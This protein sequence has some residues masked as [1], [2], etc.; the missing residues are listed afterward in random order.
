LQKKPIT[1]ELELTNE[2]MKRIADSVIELRSAMARRVEETEARVRELGPTPDRQLVKIIR[3]A[4][5]ERHVALREQAEKECLGVLKPQQRARLREIQLQAE[6]PLAFT[7]PELVAALKMSP[8]QAEL[9]RRA[10]EEGREQIVSSSVV[11]VYSSADKRPS[12]AASQTA[13]VAER[14]AAVKETTEARLETKNAVF[15]LLNKWQRDRY[16]RML[17]KSFD[18]GSLRGGN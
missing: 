13:N 12:A 6:G 2:Q 17:G 10:V 9:V 4:S 15:E 18:L 7:R 16:K 11:S 1:K 8:E 5:A 14:R 3:K